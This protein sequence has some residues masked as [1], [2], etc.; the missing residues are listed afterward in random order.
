[1]ELEHTSCPMCGSERKGNAYSNFFPYKVVRCY[2]CNF[3]YLSP[4]PT[5][6][7][8]LQLYSEEAYFEGEGNGYNSYLEQEMA[9][10]ATF[11]RL[12]M[13][14]KRNCLTGG[15]L[16]EIGCGYGYL[17]E[18]AKNFYRIRVGTDFSSQ[19]VEQARRRAN[20]IYQGGIEQIPSGEKFDCI[21]AT[22]VIE[23]VYQ[24]KTFLKQLSN[25]LLPGGK[26]LIA[27]PNMGSFWRY[28]MGHRWPSFKI[29][30]HVLYFDKKSLSTLMRQVG[31]ISIKPL[32]Y[33]HAFPLPLIAAKLNLKPPSVL[34]KFNL[35]LPATTLALY[36][37]SPSN[38]SS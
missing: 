16:L 22:Q 30:E 21:I 29:P 4:R 23:H 34:N 28:M 11:R 10:R 38:L 31:L 26:I 9:L 12:M 8:M 24:P 36:G 2:S 19:A 25:H 18:E 32:P 7:S 14:M 3:Y 13:N 1:M 5:E 20:H 37:T 35:W 27:T 17:L 6:A 15:T 33:P